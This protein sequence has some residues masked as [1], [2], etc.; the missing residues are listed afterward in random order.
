LATASISHPIDYLTTYLP[1]EDNG[2]YEARRIE[3]RGDR[4]APRKP[5]T[6]AAAAGPSDDTGRG[7]EVTADAGRCDREM[8]PV[9]QFT[10]VSLML[11]DGR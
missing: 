8:T 4:R 7:N 1:I 3:K 10:R 11:A 5:T 6:A 9:S 2:D